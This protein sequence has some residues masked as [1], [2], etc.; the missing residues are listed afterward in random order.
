MRAPLRASSRVFSPADAPASSRRRPLR[1]SGL[2]LPA[3]IQSRPA[4]P[5]APIFPGRPATAALQPSLRPGHPPRPILPTT[6]ATRRRAA[7][8]AAP[9]ANAAAD[10]AAGAATGCRP[11]LCARTAQPPQPILPKS[12]PPLPCNRTRAD[13]FALPAN[14]TLKPHGSGQP[15]PEPI[16]KKME[17][18]FNTSFADGRQI[19]RPEPHPFARR[20]VSGYSLGMSRPP[21]AAAGCLAIKRRMAPVRGGDGPL[22]QRNRPSY[23]VA[24]G[25]PS[26]CGR[27]QKRGGLTCRMQRARKPR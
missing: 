21:R 19:K 4:F 23:A 16:Q 3:P 1:Q 6:D 24:C 15:L 22:R 27:R 8:D 20:A 25:A 11:A 9:P 10:P 5:P 14:F 12:T 7:R 26:Y 17:S 2:H 18:F 13:A